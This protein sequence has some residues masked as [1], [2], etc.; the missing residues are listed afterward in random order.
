MDIEVLRKQLTEE[1]Q[2]QFESKLREAKRQK[3]QAEEELENAAE[4]WRTERRRLNSEIDRLETEIAEAK[5]RQRTADVKPAA[6]P[7]EEVTKLQQVAEE[8]LNKATAEWQGERGQLG[9][10]KNRPE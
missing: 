10:R 6:L 9:G 8:K 7:P 3:T 2:T 5:T 1:I 4:R